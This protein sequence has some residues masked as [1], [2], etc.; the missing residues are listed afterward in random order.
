MREYT[1][2][3]RGVAAV[4]LLIVGWACAGCS[5]LSKQE[6]DQFDIYMRNGQRYYDGGRYEQA[7]QQIRQA[8]EIKEDDK[9]TR[10]M[11]AWTLLQLGSPQQLR[12][13]NEEF[14]S[15]VRKHDDDY[16]VRLGYGTTQYKIALLRAKQIPVLERRGDIELL[17]RAQKEHDDAL[18]VAKSEFETVLEL[19]PD[20]PSALSNL[21]QVLALEGDADGAVALFE[22]FLGLAEKTRRYLE[23]QKRSRVITADQLE[24]LNAKIDRNIRREVTVRDLVANIYFDQGRPEAA[25]DQLTRI[26]ALEPNWIDTY[27]QRARCWSRLAEYDKAVDDVETFLRKTD[28]GFEDPVVKRANELLKEFVAKL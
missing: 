25:I 6:Q 16:R 14:E 20:D 15:L 11:L 7:E 26:L 5:G 13:A 10:L 24:I 28:R 4:A 18:E 22:R 23:G 27:L 8:L 17:E 1:R 9:K 3:I 21:G 19:N 12:E 2:G